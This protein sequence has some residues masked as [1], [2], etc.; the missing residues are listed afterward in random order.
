MSKAEKHPADSYHYQPELKCC[1]T[2]KW[3][4]RMRFGPTESLW[5]LLS[6]AGGVEMSVEEKGICDCYERDAQ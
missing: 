2:C 1:G 6:A 4:A 5:C 3:V